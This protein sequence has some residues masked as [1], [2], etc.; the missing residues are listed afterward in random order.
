MYL[1]SKTNLLSLYLGIP[2]YVFGPETHMTAIC[3]MALGKK[4]I[5]K[6]C[7]VHFAT[8]N[9]LLPSGQQEA[10][11]SKKSSTSSSDGVNGKEFKPSG[12]RQ[13]LASVVLV[14]HAQFT[15]YRKRTVRFA[16]FCITLFLIY[17]P[18]YSPLAMHRTL[19]QWP[20]T[21]AIHRF[22]HSYW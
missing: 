10:E 19:H 13:C 6:S 1:I 17:C 11:S 12:A 16:L 21:K 5:P 7:D 8:A 22:N 9:F 15:S 14:T 4:P 3:G 18:S 2:L 20:C